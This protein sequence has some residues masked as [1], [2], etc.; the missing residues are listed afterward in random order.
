M[1]HHI[2]MRTKCPGMTVQKEGGKKSLS[3]KEQIDK[4]YSQTK[5]I[6]FTSY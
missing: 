4:K 2:R 6:S 3:G 1:K 5:P